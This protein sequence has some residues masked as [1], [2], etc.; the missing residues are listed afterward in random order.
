MRIEI[1]G[2]RSVELGWLPV[3]DYLD[4]SARALQALQHYYPTWADAAAGFWWGRAIW[5]ADE[6][7]TPEGA[8]RGLGETHETLTN[9][10]IHPQSPWRVAPLHPE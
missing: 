7:K 8:K 2:G 6:I 9:L 3:D 4:Y 1:V 5:M 10:L